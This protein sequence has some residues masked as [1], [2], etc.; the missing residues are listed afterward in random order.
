MPVARWQVGLFA[1]GI[2][3][4]SIA[5]L[6]PIDPLSDQLFFMHMIQHLLITSVGVPLVIFGAPFFVSLRGLPPVFRRKVYIPLI[7]NKFLR[8]G[9]RFWQRPLVALVLYQSVYWFWHVPRFY[10]MALLNDVF[11]LLEHATMAAAAMFLWRVIID[12]HPLKSPLALPSRLLFLASIEASSVGL[13]AYL[14]FTDKVVYAYEGLPQPS[15]WTFDRIQ[16]QRLGGLI[17]WVPGGFLT[18][19]AMTIVFFVW[20][21]KEGRKDQA[22]EKAR[23]LPA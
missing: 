22:S 16:D 14:T 13:S 4:L 17:M 21:S 5:L 23:L 7:R 19:I 6:P 1:T 18:F 3:V 15:W 10:N 8:A 11:H 9:L 20:T 12:P 2:M